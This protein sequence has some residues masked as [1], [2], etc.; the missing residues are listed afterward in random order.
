ME[1]KSFSVILHS[2][3]E[4]TT[5]GVKGKLLYLSYILQTERVIKEVG[6]ILIWLEIRIL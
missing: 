2:N 6:L 3:L 5:T 1:I 4:K